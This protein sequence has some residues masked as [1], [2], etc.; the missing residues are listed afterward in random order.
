[1]ADE[2]ALDAVLAALLLKDFMSP[3][4]VARQ[5]T[6]PNPP[7][8]ARIYEYVHNTLTHAVIRD[9]LVDAFLVNDLEDEDEVA[10]RAHV[11]ELQ[12]DEVGLSTVEISD[13]PAST[14]E[15]SGSK[16][17][18]ASIVGMGITEPTGVSREARL[19]RRVER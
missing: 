6:G 19:H 8:I 7:F 1:M 2:D 18:R 16:R 17:M 14:P 11:L 9:R 3:L 15:Y 10:L 13:L 12:A 4:K 5:T